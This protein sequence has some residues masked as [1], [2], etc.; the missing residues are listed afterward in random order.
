MHKFIFG[1]AGLFLAIVCSAQPAVEPQSSISLKEQNTQHVTRCVSGAAAHHSVNP[2]ILR[3]ILQ[4]E[5]GNKPDALNRNNNGSIDVGIAQINSMHFKELGRYGI[6]PSDL[7]NEC[8]S[9]YVAAWHLAKQYR[10]YGNTWFA[11]GAYHSA[12]PCFNRR[13][14]G[15]VWN[16]LVDFKAVGGGKQRVAS[17]A[18]C[19]YAV[20][21][22]QPKNQ[23]AFIQYSPSLTYDN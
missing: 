3:A 16:A 4:V 5:S 8:V 7:M 12:T 15:L 19:G 1:I 11:I 21:Q 20:A 10:A 6:S 13:Y 18:D 14:A 2:W 22:R 23:Q 17:L 9:T